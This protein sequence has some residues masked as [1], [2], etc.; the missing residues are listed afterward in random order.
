MITGLL[1]N[2][3]LLQLDYFGEVEGV[4]E[5]G[6]KEVPCTEGQTSPS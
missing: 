4:A 5:R 3:L 1:L 6:K 2:L